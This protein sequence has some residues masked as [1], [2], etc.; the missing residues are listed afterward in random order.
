[1]KSYEEML[2][3]YF[4]SQLTDEQKESIKIKEY[5]ENN[6]SCPKDNNDLIE[7]FDETFMCSK[8]GEYYYYEDNKLNMKIKK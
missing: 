2:D 4:E 1:M 7:V 3:K 8:C 6:L 5:V